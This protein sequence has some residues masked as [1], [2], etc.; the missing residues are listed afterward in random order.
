MRKSI[1]AM[2]LIEKSHYGEVLWLTQWNG[3]WNRYNLI[4]GHCEKDEA[5]RDCIKRELEEELGITQNQFRVVDKP[6]ERLKYTGYSESHGEDTEYTLEVY[7]TRILSGQALKMPYSGWAT[8][9][10]NRTTI[11]TKAVLLIPCG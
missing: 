3:H 11:N 5:F 4:A 9:K 10:L 2:A 7:E 8:V 1:G 6:L